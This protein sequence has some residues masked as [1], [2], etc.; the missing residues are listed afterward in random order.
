M[1][2]S[3][4]PFTGCS[5]LGIMQPR[6]NSL[7]GSLNVAWILKPALPR[8]S[9]SSAFL[10]LFDRPAAPS[11]NALPNF[12]FQT[13]ELTRGGRAFSGRRAC[14]LTTAHRPTVRQWSAC[15]QWS[16]ALSHSEP[17]TKRLSQFCPECR[18]R[19]GLCLLLQ[20]TPGFRQPHVPFPPV[21]ARN[22]GDPIV[23]LH[24]LQHT[25]SV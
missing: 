19:S 6:I 13:V 18:A 24:H 12:C 5:A 25:G 22:S 7:P 21:F 15:Q 2:A 3:G 10:S 14:A 23:F 17:G 4:Q 11:M 16:R 1:G 20:L 8:G 9:R